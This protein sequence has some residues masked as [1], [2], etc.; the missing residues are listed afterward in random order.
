[1]GAK[2]RKPSPMMGAV[3]ELV[4]N[5]PSTFLSDATSSQFSHTMELDLGTIDP[6]PSQ[7]R[8]VFDKDGIRS[9]ASTMAE[10]GQLQP[11]LVRRNPEEKGR[12]VIVAGERRW[13]AAKRLGWA[14]ILAAVHEG[15]ASVA[16]LLENLQRVDLNVV[17]E[18]RA[19]RKLL[20]AR[21]WTQSQVAAAVG[22]NSTDLNGA[23]G[24]LDLPEVFLDKLLNSE[25][26]VS[27]NALIELARVPPGA[28]RDRLIEAAASGKLTIPLIRGER[29]AGARSGATK[30]TG[31][32]DAGAGG[33]EI[34]API[35]L[36]EV[37]RLRSSILRT[38][39]GRR[40]LGSA[41]REELQEL[42]REIAELLSLSDRSFA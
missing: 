10:E 1:M 26:S 17:E 15:D 32:P 23:L 24:V 36:K 6:D 7:A 37:G 27:R 22:R 11:I 42:A 19:L 3:A 20:D 33:I 8:R 25:V 12:W 14:R 39:E 30:R 28:G 34:P 38:R 35:S 13:R 9:L 16:A 29:D 5:L 18:A 4:D 41:E 21:G 31:G 40:V 2:P